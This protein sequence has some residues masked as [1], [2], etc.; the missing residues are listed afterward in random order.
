MNTPLK[1]IKIINV[2]F[3]LYIVPG[4]FCNIF[5]IYV[6]FAEKEADKAKKAKEG[7][8]AGDEKKITEEENAGVEKKA[9]EAKK[10][11]DKKKEED[12]EEH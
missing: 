11:G 10:A 9:K 4:L 8:K 1:A 5:C 6:M 12:E 2:F 7:R 3:I